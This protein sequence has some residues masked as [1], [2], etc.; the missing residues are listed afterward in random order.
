MDLLARL[1]FLLRPLTGSV[2]ARA[3]VSAA[4]LALVLSR[5][6]VGSV[7]DRLTSGRWG[8]FVAAVA[9]VLLALLLAAFRWHFFLAAS[10]LERTRTEA[11]RAYMIGAF[12]T[13]FLPSQVGGDV[14]RAWIAGRSGMR[15]RALATVAVDR[16]TLLGCLIVLGWLVYAAD[17]RP[18]PNSLV[19]AL[20]AASAALTVIVGVPIAFALGGSRLSRRL[21]ARVLGHA[22]DARDALHDCLNRSL[23]AKTTLLGLVY[24][25]MILGEAWLVARAIDLHVAFSVL[26]VTFPP[27]LILAALPIS[28]GGLGV[29]EGGFVV[30]LGRA[31]VSATDATLFS[32]LAAA[33]FSLATLPGALALLRRA[34]V[35]ERDAASETPGHVGTAGGQDSN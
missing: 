26:A 15:I 22:R 5:I 13:N 4:L 18:V 32:L 8:L 12:T 9:V 10:G 1:L 25:A 2:W 35:D 17:P 16:A 31:G 24:Q 29:R 3:L 23:L 34:H 20:G 27:V 6:E 33:A 21:P 11:V 14:T 7:A 30:L 19:G 28:I